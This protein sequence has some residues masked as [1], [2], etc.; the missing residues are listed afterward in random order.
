MH[1]IV[2][3]V[4]TYHA[5]TMLISPVA[6]QNNLQTFTGT[7]GATIA[8]AV[9][10]SG[11]QFQ[12]QGNALFNALDNALARSCDIQNNQCA[13]AANAS[14]NKNGLTVAACDAQH[15]QCESLIPA[16]P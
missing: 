5:L 13:D 14:G 3:F 15:Y 2:A 10:Q 1:Q 4:V 11:A 12:V 7:L 6:A 9:T 8:P 16:N